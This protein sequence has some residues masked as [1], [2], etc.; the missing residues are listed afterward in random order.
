MPLFKNQYYFDE[1]IFQKE[2]EILFDYKNAY[3]G[4]ISLVPNA[5]DYYVLSHLNNAWVLVR[6]QDGI[7]VLNNVCRHRQ[8]VLL[9]GK[10]NTQRIVCPVH[11]WTYQ[12]NG[13]LSRSPGFGDH[14]ELNLYQEEDI[15]IANGFIFKNFEDT[16]QELQ[17]IELLHQFD[18]AEY[19]FLQANQ[20][21]YKVGWKE[22]VDVFLD[23][24]HI[25]YFHPGLCSFVNTEETEWYYGNTYCI[26]KT[27]IKPDFRHLIYPKFRRYIDSYFRNFPEIIFEFG[28]IWGML[29]PNIMWSIFQQFFVITIVIPDSINTCTTYKQIYCHKQAADKK[30]LTRTFIEVVGEI[31]EEDMKVIYN[32][33]EGRESLYKIG[34]ESAGPYQNPTEQGMQHFHTYLL[35]KLNLM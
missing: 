7:E 1:T 5:G 15:Q 26:Q 12:L 28:A 14:L 18:F 19:Q 17:N 3:L 16:V 22:Y 20:R 27:G 9:K 32:I 24:N 35:K 34:K 2:K 11:F 13:K 4:Q 30:D 6:S 31:E 8:S 23:H 29:Y 21:Q 25:N 10:G 33:R